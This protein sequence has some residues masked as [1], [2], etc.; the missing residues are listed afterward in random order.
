[1]LACRSRCVTPPLASQRLKRNLV[2]KH[3]YEFVSI[4]EFIMRS[5][6][7]NSITKNF[8]YPLAVA[9]KKKKSNNL[10]KQD[11]LTQHL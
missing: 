2:Q 11:Y 9:L 3:S 4:I 5:K 6:I 1:M 8:T 10:M 7:I